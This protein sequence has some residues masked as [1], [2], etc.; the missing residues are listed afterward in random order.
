MNPPDPPI[1]VGS[2]AGRER[3]YKTDYHVAELRNL[4]RWIVAPGAG[5]GLAAT[6]FR[7]WYDAEYDFHHLAFELEG[8]H[9]DVRFYKVFGL[10]K[11]L[12]YDF[13]RGRTFPYAMSLASFFHEGRHRTWVVEDKRTRASS[14]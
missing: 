1:E 12:D 13:V 11:N 14:A 6:G 5:P 10:T 4:A 3:F 2:L 7:L 8:D 9:Y